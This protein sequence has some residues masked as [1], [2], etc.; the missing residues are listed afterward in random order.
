V[1][2]PG[3]RGLA[4]LGHLVER[5]E[6]WA[7]DILPRQVG[8]DHDRMDPQFGVI[9]EQPAAPEEPHQ[10]TPAVFADKD[11]AATSSKFLASYCGVVTQ[12]RIQ[13][14]VL[15]RPLCIIEGIADGTLLRLVIGRQ[16]RASHRSV[17]R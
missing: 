1:A 11:A 5:R 4:C 8:L 2:S 17:G 13:L 7:G 15:S 10:I 12:H 14:A 16:H 3:L 9:L 6:E